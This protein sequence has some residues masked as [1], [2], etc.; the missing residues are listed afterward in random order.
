MLSKRVCKSCHRV[1]G[2]V[3]DEYWEEGEV[4]CPIGAPRKFRDIGMSS[5]M[6]NNNDGDP[7]DEC[8]YR[9]EHLLALQKKKH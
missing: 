5:E 8:P 1:W 2:K 7:P 9:L 3:D 4:F 6:V